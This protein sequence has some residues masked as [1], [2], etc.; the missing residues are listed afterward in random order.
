[1]GDEILR[2]I[3]D[4]ADRLRVDRRTL[5]HSASG[6]AA[7]L[8]VFNLAG[9][10]GGGGANSAGSSSTSE[11]PA[12]SDTSSPESTG[13]GG[14]FQAP[15]PTDRAAC[16]EVF[17]GNEFIF[18]IH[19]HH[20]VPNGPWR[21]SAPSIA[22][23]IRPLV[24]ESCTAKDPFECL[25][26]I[27]F[28]QDFF[29]ASDTTIALLSDVPNSGPEDAPVP[30]PEALRTKALADQLMTGSASRVLLHN[31]IAPNF[32]DLSARLDEM[33]G[34]ASTG[35]VA[36]FKVYTAWGPRNQ[37]YAIDDPR[38]GLPVLE[39]ARRLGVKIMCA[40]KGLPIQGFDQRF[41][42]PADVV[43][44]AR[45]YP[46]MQFIVYHSAFERETIESSYSPAAASR[47]VNS[48]V[49][50]MIDNGLPPNA[51]VWADLGTTWRELMRKPTEAA[52][53]VGKLL[54][55]IGED[56]VLW[57]TDAI[58]YGSPQPQI[59]AFRAFQITAEF[60]ERFGYPALTDTIKRKILGLNAAKLFGIDVNATRCAL[61]ADKL[62]ASR[63]EFASLVNS[64][65][66]TAPWQARGPLSRREVISF[67]HNGGRIG[68]G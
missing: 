6:V 43:A 12:A 62:A 20:V 15:N 27:S 61:N 28:L 13:P 8:A 59:M 23:M 60:Q 57:G 56:R 42:G 54:R 16:D 52:H 47:G 19:A 51:N 2:R 3:A 34:A 31:V 68:V 11:P 39:H 63:P 36:A 48:F 9:C 65:R 40:H 24:P 18:D 46:D 64:Q 37:G 55:Y 35:K 58:W 26:R 66:L 33:A 1:M 44:A 38:I 49:K 14:T 32:G 7:T 10:S 25:D 29:L 41:N 67:L 50:A 22:A 53:C 30:W 5:L 21:Q 45:Q 4:T 17:A